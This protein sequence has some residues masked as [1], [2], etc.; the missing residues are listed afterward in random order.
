VIVPALPF[1]CNRNGNAHSPKTAPAGKSC[2]LETPIGGVPPVFWASA[3]G[4]KKMHENAETTEATAN[5]AFRM[6]T[7]SSLV[8]TAR[9]AP[10]C[11]RNWGMILVFVNFA[12]ETSNVNQGLAPGFQ[13]SDSR[14]WRRNS[15]S[16]VV[17][18]RA[19]H[20]SESQAERG[21]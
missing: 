9:I 15:K 14:R 1:S 2:E 13:P 20:P 21:C 8:M 10:D 11:P 17:R 12:I 4:G 16:L 3:E 7:F 18:Q 6:G 19:A 5:D